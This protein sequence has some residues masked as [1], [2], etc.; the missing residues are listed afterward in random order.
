MIYDSSHGGIVISEDEQE[1]CNAQYVGVH[2]I[3][4][5]H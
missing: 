2:V 3:G 1:C 5:H 4:V